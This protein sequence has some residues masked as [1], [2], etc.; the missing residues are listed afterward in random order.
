MRSTYFKNFFANA[1]L[2]VL[3]FLILGMAFTLLSR[4]YLL[5]ERRGSMEINAGEVSRTAV[6]FAENGDLGNWDLRMMITSVAHSTGN[7][8]LISN[9]EGLIVACSDK[10]LF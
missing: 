3:S 2:S 9:P 10:E 8:I 6:A 1:A 5:D 7:E 4:S